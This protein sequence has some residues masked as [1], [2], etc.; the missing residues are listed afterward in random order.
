MLGQLDLGDWIETATGKQ[1]WSIQRKIAT[2][3]SQPYAKVAVPSCVS[4]GKFVRASEPVLA[5]GGWRRIDSLAV[6]DLIYAQDGTLTEVTGVFP[7]GKQQL[8]RF[9]LSNGITV[10]SGGPHLWAVD[11]WEPH[12]GAARYGRQRQVLTTDEIVQRYGGLDQT[13]H[14]MKR[15][16]LPMVEP[17]Q[18][19][20]VDVPLD[21]YALGL[22]LGDGG[23]TT[24]TPTFSTADQELLDAFEQVRHRSGYDYGVLGISAIVDSLGLSGKRAWEKFVPEQYLWNDPSVRLAVLQGL[25]DTDGGISGVGTEFCT[26]SQKIAEN[27]RF[28]VQSLGGRASLRERRTTYTYKGERKLGRVSY[29]MSITL[30]V[31]PFRLSRK[32][33]QWTEINDR[34]THS[35]AYT[36]MRV[37]KV[38]ADDAVCISVAHPDKLFVID[39]FLVTHNTHLAARIALAFFDA[40]TPG[41]PCVYCGPGDGTPGPCKG[42][43]IITTSSK[44][45]HL[46][47]NLWGELRTAF[48]VVAQRVGISGRLLPGDLRVEAGPNHFIIGQVSSNAEGFQGYHCFDD[49]TEILTDRGWLLFEDVKLSDQI[50]TLNGDVAEWGP[51]TKIHQHEFDGYLNEHDGT[52]VNFAITDNHRL[53]AHG[54]T[55]KQWRIAEY[56]DLPNTF[57]IRRTNEW[58]GTSPATMEFI[59][60]DRRTKGYSFDFNDWAEFLGWYISEG[61]SNRQGVGISQDK[62]MNPAKCDE[63]RSLLDRMGVAYWQSD[64]GFTF[65]STLIAAHL[66]EHCGVG[67]LNKRVPEYLKNAGTTAMDRFLDAFG[68]GAGTPHNGGKR[69]Y[70][71]SAQLADDL[72]EMLAKLGRARSLTSHAGTGFSDKPMYVIGDPKK[73]VDSTVK[74]ANV[75]QMRYKGYVWCVSTPHQTIMVRRKGRAMWSGNSSHVLVVGDEA[76]SVDEAVSQGIFGLLASGDARL[77]L[78]F[79]PTTPDTYAARQAASSNVTTIKITAWDTPEFTGEPKPDGAEFINDKFLAD[80]RAAGM[81]EGTY[82][83]TTRVLADFWEMSDTALIS[84]EWVR[85]AKRAPVAYGIRA[86]GVDLAPYGTSENVIAYRNGNVLERIDTFPSMRPDLFWQ[87]PVAEAVKQ[88][89]PQYL[90]YDADGV[91]A[92]AVGEAMRVARFMPQGQV[93]PFR[94]A[95]KTQGG[96]SNARAAWYWALRRR[97]ENGQLVLGCEDHELE[98][99]LININ[100]SI[101]PS[102]QIRVERKE[103][104]K[105]RGMASPDRAD[106]CLVAGTLVRT[107]R[108]EVPIE[109][110]TTSDKV[111]TRS[112][113]RK[114]LRSWMT[115]P[116]AETVTVRLDSGATLS[117]TSDHPVWDGQTWRTLASFQIGDIL[118]SWQTSL[119]SMESGTGET[120]TPHGNISLGTTGLRADTL[121]NA[122]C[123]VSSTSMSTGHTTVRCRSF[124]TLTEIHST[125]TPATFA[126]L[127]EK[128]TQPSTAQAVR[129]NGWRRFALWRPPGIAAMRDGSGILTTGSGSPSSAKPS[130][131]SVRHV[132]LQPSRSTQND[133]VGAAPPVISVVVGVDSSSPAA[134]YNLEV[135]DEHEYLANGILAHNCMYAF[136]LAEDLP[137]PSVQPEQSVAESVFGVRDNSDRAMW[138]RD[139]APYAARARKINPVLGVPDDDW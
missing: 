56:K 90:I 70:T 20:T 23:L 128:S 39:N 45:E 131:S 24:R 58:G 129:Q 5:E 49:K 122:L 77:L 4:S 63:I 27:V 8:Y 125:T 52:K 1:L 138:D 84:A 87:G 132:A 65:R 106:G 30:S 123:T 91:G 66:Q 115:S 35:M 107:M 17:V 47:N 79:N 42:A 124:T 9:H 92:G 31:C 137:M 117:G 41:T 134:V 55:N 86:L 89:D 36:I 48:P 14:S 75:R 112:G 18:F 62:A 74:K 2:A 102:G 46:K 3:I 11:G 72:H 21:P 133:P 120:P 93:L 16:S 40:Y 94:G 15:L 73:P 98:K 13:P 32:A 38:D 33:A 53:I 136:A 28:L 44:W 54:K 108:G 22:L 116:E 126:P 6:G 103:E 101:T 96:Y 105:K 7:Q 88:F 80:M 135:E 104:M 25:M 61:Y 64:N 130:S 119:C 50:L 83:W 10:D 43:K 82:E 139:L 127:R 109:S 85:N 97:F 118:P 68:K 60:E 113:W 57:T 81:G 71:G 114:V 59:A 121:T 19:P 51:V 26:T 78:I 76:T 37:E 95:L 67:A 99:Q 34:R 110:V 12:P 111:L 29:R 69:Y 100:Y